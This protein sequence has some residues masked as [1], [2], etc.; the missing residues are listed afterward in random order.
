[1]Q[2]ESTCF[3][4]QTVKKY[5]DRYCGVYID[6]FP[7]FG[8]P[9]LDKQRN[10]LRNRNENIKR[11]NIRRRF[12]LSDERSFSGKIFWLINSPKKLFVKFDYYTQLQERILSAFPLNQSDMIFFPWRMKPEKDKRGCYKDI[13]YYDD[14]KSAVKVE[15]ED[16]YINVPVG[17][18][19]YLRMDFGDYMKLPPKEKQV[20]MHPSALID[21]NKSY[22]EFIGK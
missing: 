9:Q 18:E 8:L 10:K 2:D 20:A 15:F 19:R 16:G 21:L 14:F 22:K 12:P 4:E 11:L 7:I 3:V 13:F 5:E 17:Y 6:I 1:M